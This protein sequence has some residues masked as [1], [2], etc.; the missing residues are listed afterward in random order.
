M[1]K[2]ECNVFWILCAMVLFITPIIIRTL[3]VSYSQIT[4]DLKTRYRCIKDR[5]ECD[6]RYSLDSRKHQSLGFTA[7]K[8]LH[9]SLD[10]LC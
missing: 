8:N 1:R 10:E 4:V 9:Y 7:K 2:K 5:N 3:K 6:F